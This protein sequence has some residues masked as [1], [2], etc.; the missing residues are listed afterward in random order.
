[1]AR[2][3][4]KYGIYTLLDMHQVCR[5]CAIVSLSMISDSALVWA[6]DVMSDKFCGEGLPRWAVQ[7]SGS[8]SFPEPV[9]GKYKNDPHSGQLACCQRMRCPALTN[10]LVTSGVPSF[11]D[12]QRLAWSRYYFS[13]A[14]GTAFQVCFSALPSP[15]LFFSS[16]RA[17]AQLTHR[18]VT[19]LHASGT[20][21]IPA[22][23]S[24]TLHRHA[25]L[26]TSIWADRCWLCARGRAGA[27]R[28]QGWALRRVGRDVGHR[29]HRFQ[30]RISHPR[31]RAHQ[32]T[33]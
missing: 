2:N 17:H 31:R 19:A 11:Q 25:S 23:I 20:L 18:H 1:M 8:F 28:Q 29:R 21:S 3:A 22:N 24:V 9:K 32:R 14:T 4:S 10:L 27:L 26:H 16:V 30:R 6:Q 7:P 13:E 15:A 12:C 5:C 33:L